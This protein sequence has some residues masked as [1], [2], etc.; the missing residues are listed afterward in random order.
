MPDLDQPIIFP[1]QIV[2][3]VDEDGETVTRETSIPPDTKKPKEQTC[4][5]FTTD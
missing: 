2:I 1:G 5:L 4:L 3:D